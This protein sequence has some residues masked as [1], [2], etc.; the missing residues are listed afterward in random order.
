MFSLILK[1]NI[2]LTKNCN[3]NSANKMQNI[4]ISR[5]FVILHYREQFIHCQ[6]TKLA[7][8][9]LGAH[10]HN[11]FH[12]QKSNLQLDHHNQPTDLPITSQTLL[13]ISLPLHQ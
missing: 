6:P 10:E 3:I 7:C 11:I 2:C 8:L 1:K 12:V 4:C 9:D 13:R 5:V